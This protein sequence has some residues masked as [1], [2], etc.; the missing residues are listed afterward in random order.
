[1]VLLKEQKDDQEIGKGGKLSGA[2]YPKADTQV[3]GYRRRHAAG[4]NF[5]RQEFVHQANPQEETET[6]KVRS[7][8]A[9]P[10]TLHTSLGLLQA[11]HW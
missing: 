5:R 9:S 1:M 10:G 11:P 8:H 7:P 3:V 2:D 4:D 6:E